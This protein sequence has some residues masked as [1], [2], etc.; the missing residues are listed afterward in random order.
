[1]KAR[2]TP[3]RGVLTI[4][5]QTGKLESSVM[6]EH[7]I[8]NLSEMAEYCK[9]RTTDSCGLYNG[10][11]ENHMHERDPCHY[12]QIGFLGKKK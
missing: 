1:N 8:R 7:E 6:E 2:I 4:F 3:T 11:P 5:E 10:N 12:S 9:Y